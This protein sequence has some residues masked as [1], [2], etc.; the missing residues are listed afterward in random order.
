MLLLLPPALCW[1]CLCQTI[2][3]LLQERENGQL[4]PTRTPSPG[5]PMGL[6]LPASQQHLGVELADT[7][8]KIRRLR[9]EL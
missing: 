5:D 9:Q 8:A 6:H 3:E 4:T 2:M 1:A 7:K